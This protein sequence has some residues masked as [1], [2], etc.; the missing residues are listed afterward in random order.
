MSNGYV[1]SSSE[2]TKIDSLI[3][4]LYKKNEDLN[5]VLDKYNDLAASS[6]EVKKEAIKKIIK[7]QESIIAS[8]KAQ[9]TSIMNQTT[10]INRKVAAELKR[11]AQLKEAKTNENSTD[12][13]SLISNKNR[14]I[15]R[16]HDNNFKENM[17]Y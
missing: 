11:K 3:N 4:T 10:E 16:L 13:S 2:I 14:E 1:D 12:K 6:I 8:L 17:I 7:K 9:K 5:N 15:N